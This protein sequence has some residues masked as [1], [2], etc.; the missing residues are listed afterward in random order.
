MV[1]VVYLNVY[2]RDEPEAFSTR[3]RAD[4]ANRLASTWGRP[5]R[6]ALI[7]IA[8]DGQNAF[9]SVVPQPIALKENNNDQG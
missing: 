3:T 4:Y 7:E 1:K 8:I 6:Q 9:A 2:E 5:Q